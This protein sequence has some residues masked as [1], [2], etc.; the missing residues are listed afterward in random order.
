MSLVELKRVSKHYD[1]GL[2]TALDDVSLSIPEGVICALVGPSGCGKTSLL[3]IVG[4]LDLPTTGI[5]LFDG[6]PVPAGRAAENFRN[7]ELGFVFQFHNLLPT[8]T[9]AENVELP[10]Q[11]RRDVSRRDRRQRAYQILD[12]LGLSHRA[13]HRANKVSGGERQ[14]AAIARA[15]VTRPRLVLADEPTGNIDSR[16]AAHVMSVLVR[17]AEEHGATCLIATH[18]D[19]IA[20][21][22]DRIITLRDGGVC[23]D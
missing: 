17:E 19:E 3:N 7:R 21:S 6:R 9:L 20:S 23:A 14:R 16:T 1:D 2:V 18:N 15:L 13:D 8:L 5:A 11:A 22:A 10:L 12:D 4:S